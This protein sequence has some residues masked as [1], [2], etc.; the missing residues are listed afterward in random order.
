MRIKDESTK[1]ERMWNTTHHARGNDTSVFGEALKHA[2]HHTH[3]T[4]DIGKDADEIE[5]LHYL[6]LYRCVRDP[7]IIHLKW[8]ACVYD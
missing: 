6:S 1:I 2:N 3:K 5:P 4:V 8:N 7:G